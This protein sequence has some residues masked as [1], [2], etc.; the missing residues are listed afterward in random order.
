MMHHGGFVGAWLF[1]VLSVD[2]ASTGLPAGVSD[3]YFTNA[4]AGPGGQLYRGRAPQQLLPE[5]RIFD[6]ARDSK[7]RLVV[8]F[9]SGDEHEIR[10]TRITPTGTQSS[11]NWSVPRSTQFRTTRFDTREWPLNASWMPG[12]YRVDLTID[13]VPAGSYTF[14]VK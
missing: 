14:E 3:I 9:R 2:C 4:E 7:V 12:Q 1:V 11:F 8:V 13:G 10:V 5:V 6:R